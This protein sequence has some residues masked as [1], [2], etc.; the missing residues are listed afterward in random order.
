MRFMKFRSGAPRAGVRCGSSRDGVPREPDK[1]VLYAT[2]QF[3]RCCVSARPCRAE[4]Q[5]GLH[6]LSIL[7]RDTNSGE[8]ISIDPGRYDTSESL[9]DLAKRV[10]VCFGALATSDGISVAGEPVEN[11]W[12]LPVVAICE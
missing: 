8:P 1:N 12:A 5:S 9:L 11:L 7:V 6:G 4:P 10:L 2:P 3:N